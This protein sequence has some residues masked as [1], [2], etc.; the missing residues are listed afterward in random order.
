MRRWDTTFFVD[1]TTDTDGYFIER[2]AITATVYANDRERAD[3]IL[4]AW[5]PKFGS[6]P[7]PERIPHTSTAAPNNQPEGVFFQEP[8][9]LVWKGFYQEAPKVPEAAANPTSSSRSS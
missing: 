7:G 1:Y 3:E 4:G 8:R 9:R 5:M 2:Y 6:Y